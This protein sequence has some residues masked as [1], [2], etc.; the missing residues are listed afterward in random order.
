MLIQVA[1]DDEKYD[2][3]KDFMLDRLIET[4]AISKF[5]RSSGWVRVGVDPIRKRTT[6]SKAIEPGSRSEAET[7]SEAEIRSET[8]TG[9]ERR[10]ANA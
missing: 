5:R 1:Y 2:Y 9:V 4:G 8:Y 6:R 3:V 10:A 7:R